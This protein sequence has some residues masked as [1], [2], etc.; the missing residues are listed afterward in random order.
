MLVEA[1]AP[2]GRGD[3]FIAEL[4]QQACETPTILVVNKVDRVAEASVAR[5]AGGAP[6]SWVSSTRTCP[7]PRK[8]GEGVDGAAS[9]IE[10]RL[11]EGPQYYPDGVVTDQ[12]ETFLAAELVREQLLA[13]ARDELPHSITVQ[14][15]GDRPT[16]PT[17]LPARG[18]AAPATAGHDPASS[19]IPRRG[20]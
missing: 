16:T 13:V 6:P 11:P 14:R 20:S 5:P 19:A 9:E 18:R 7:C 2:I 12:P 4:V 15:R 17:G 3:R 8:T 1:D 10:R